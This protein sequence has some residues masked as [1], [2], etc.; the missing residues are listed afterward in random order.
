MNKKI[1]LLI[2]KMNLL[3]D[4]S[5]Q[6]RDMDNKE[7]PKPEEI[8]QL[9]RNFETYKMVCDHLFPA[10]VGRMWV[11]ENIKDMPMSKLITQSDEA[12]LL[13]VVENNRDRWEDM[14]ENKKATSKISTKWSR[15]QGTGAVKFNGWDEKGLARFNRN[16]KKVKKDREENGRAFDQYYKNWVEQT[17]K[18]KKKEN[19]KE[20]H[21]NTVIVDNDLDGLD[22]RLFGNPIVLG[23]PRKTLGSPRKLVHALE[24]S[25][26]ESKGE[27]MNRYE[28]ENESE[29]EGEK[30][31]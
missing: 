31:M 5:E 24:D 11:K 16:M 13:L 19:K 12:F 14:I 23:A 18:T 3:V 6:R 25:T 15:G 1:L 2:L 21:K 27:E 22:E 20:K 8:Y 29:S 9:R 7:F 10:I 28:K 17:V 26:S 30:E 4:I